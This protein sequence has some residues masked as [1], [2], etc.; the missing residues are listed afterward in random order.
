MQPPLVPKKLWESYI[1]LFSLLTFIER[2]TGLWL[3]Q[4]HHALSPLLLF[5]TIK[6]AFLL[7]PVVSSGKLKKQNIFLVLCINGLQWFTNTFFYTPHTHS[8]C[9]CTG[10]PGEMSPLSPLLNLQSE[11]NQ[12]PFLI[13]L[14]HHTALQGQ[15]TGLPGALLSHSRCTEECKKSPADA[16]LG[17]SA[18]FCAARC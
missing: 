10:Q 13:S 8:S 15:P 14:E 18:K 17:L 2:G 12:S 9:C 7:C 11:C 1:S 4:I 16:F 5:I 3:S 6:T